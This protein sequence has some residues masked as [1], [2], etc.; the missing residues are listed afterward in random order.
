MRRPAYT[1]IVNVWSRLDSGKPCSH[2]GRTVKNFNDSDR[3]ETYA[4]R[5]TDA[6]LDV[7]VVN[8]AAH[9]EWEAWK[10]TS[11]TAIG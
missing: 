8:N 2:L 7:E 5:K 11:F 1:V 10:M 4:Q 9:P 3:A 6:G